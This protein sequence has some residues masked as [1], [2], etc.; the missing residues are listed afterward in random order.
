MSRKNL[1]VGT[2]IGLVAL[3][4][5]VAVLV[6]SFSVPIAINPLGALSAAVVAV[7]GIVWFKKTNR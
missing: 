1:V 3:I 4:I 6:A 2:G 7:L 5:L